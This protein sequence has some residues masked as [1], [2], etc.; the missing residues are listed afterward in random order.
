MLSMDRQTRENKVTGFRVIKS[1]LP[2][3]KGGVQK[4][5]CLEEFFIE[6]KHMKS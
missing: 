5:E 4:E 1:E 6:E 2:K 3:R